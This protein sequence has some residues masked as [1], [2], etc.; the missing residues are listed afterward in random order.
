MASGSSSASSSSSS[1]SASP[2]PESRPAKTSKSKAAEK[3]TKVTQ[4][5][6]RNEGTDPHWAYTP[7]K[8]SVRLEESADVGDFDWDALNGNPD[9]ELWLVRIPEGVRAR[10]YEFN[11]NLSEMR[12]V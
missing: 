6:A 2:E 11:L 4:E 1:G 10:F 9:L 5:K 8:K 12:G 7:P 3:A